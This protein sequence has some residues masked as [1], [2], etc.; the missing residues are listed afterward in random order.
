MEWNARKN[1]KKLWKKKRDLYLEITCPRCNHKTMV[2][3]DKLGYNLWLKNNLKVQSL[4][5]DASKE[6]RELLISGLCIDC[7]KEVFESE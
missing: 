2:S 1:H 4:F 6:H 3:M 7:Q 5:P